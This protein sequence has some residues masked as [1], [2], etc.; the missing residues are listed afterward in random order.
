MAEN[1]DIYNCNVHSQDPERDRRGGFGVGRRV[2]E[3]E[4]LVPTRPLPD[5]RYWPTA[6]TWLSAVQ[7]PVQTYRMALCDLPMRVACDARY[8]ASVRLAT[9]LRACY[10]LSG[11]DVAYGDNQAQY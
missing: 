3:P 2:A 6:H 8:Y 5:A 7:S 4:V 11:T 1:T 10:V 9:S